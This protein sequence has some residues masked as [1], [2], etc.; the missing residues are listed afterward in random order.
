MKSH[1]ARAA[2]ALIRIRQLKWAAGYLFG[3]YVDR[4]GKRQPCVLG[5]RMGRWEHHLGTI[6]SPYTASA[7][8]LLRRSH[9]KSPPIGLE[10]ID[11]AGGRGLL[12]GK[13]DKDLLAQ[14]GMDA[15]CSLPSSQVAG[16]DVSATES[17]FHR[18]GDGHIIHALDRRAYKKGS[19]R[20][21]KR[22]VDPKGRSPRAN[23]GE[24]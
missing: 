15:G 10:S 8:R 4:Q 11:Y 17:S 23:R 19:F 21:S 13:H 3:V 1:M 18:C 24:S 6:I 20:A 7:L 14:I 12:S 5:S 16:A 22:Q 2:H 9:T